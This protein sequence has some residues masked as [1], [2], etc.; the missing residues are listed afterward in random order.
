MACGGDPDNKTEVKQF[1]ISNTQITLRVNKGEQILYSPTEAYGQLTWTSSNEQVAVVNTTTGFV[2]AVSEGN[3]TITG[4]L[5]NG[6]TATAEVAVKS[7]QDYYKETTVF[8]NYVYFQ[9][10]GDTFYYPFKNKEGKPLTFGDV[11]PNEEDKG[12]TELI[13]SVFEYHFCLLNQSLYL[14]GEG[15]MV[16]SDGL[17]VDYWSSFY[18]SA[19]ANT[20][21]SL[22]R[23]DVAKM[24]TV[25][26]KF[27]A[28]YLKFVPPYYIPASEF[29][30][31]MYLEYVTLLL[32]DQ[33]PASRDYPFMGPADQN[34]SSPVYNKG[35]NLMCYRQ[36][37]DSQTG[38]SYMGSFP[39]GT[40]EQGAIAMNGRPDRTYYA[41]AYALGGRLFGG[42]DLTGLKTQ[43]NQEK[44]TWEYVIEGEG[45]DAHFVMDELTSYEF[46]KEGSETQS[47]PQFQA[48]PADAFRKGAVIN[49]AMYIP[50]RMML[51]NNR[52]TVNK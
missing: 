33:E 32:T 19:Q 23:Y 31:D 6:F 4:T 47:A 13:D 21:F 37:T 35:V 8:E 26:P 1:T 39:Y 22:S 29:D 50:L 34:P 36:F 20:V 24:D 45:E 43:Y 46:V 25:L 2:T 5:K 42:N 28:Q 9:D 30:Q 10:G 49:N 41:Q 16:G 11:S 40:V 15:S 51:D 52:L 18:Y 27:D 48:V 7:E 17:A 12:R 44:E 14:S 38:E 3:A